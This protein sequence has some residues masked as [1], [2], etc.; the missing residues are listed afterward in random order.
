MSPWRACASQARIRE[1]TSSISIAPVA[2]SNRSSRILRRNRRTFSAFE[3][4]AHRVAPALE[5]EADER[6]ALGRAVKAALRRVEPQAQAVAAPRDRVPR[7]TEAS[8]IVV[9][10]EQVVAV[11]DERAE[12]ELRGDQVIDRREHEVGPDL[13]AQISDRQAVRAGDRRE[14]IVAGEVEPR[15]FDVGARVDD[16]L[17]ERPPRRRRAWPQQALDQRV[18]DRRKELREVEPQHV[19]VPPGQLGGGAQAAVRAEAFAARVGLWRERA[20]DRGQRRRDEQVLDDAIAERQRRDQAP[21]RLPDEEAARRAR[22]PG[23]R[24]ELRDQRQAVALAIEQERGNIRA[25]PLAPG[26]GMRGA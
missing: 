23:P 19:A 15:R 24:A 22:P 18:V 14:Q 25:A 17:G 5:H 26:G 2:W 20:L 13:R 10:D 12:A 21:L 6:H 4:D 8:R 16:P 3:R 1:V 7:G 11:T 9:E